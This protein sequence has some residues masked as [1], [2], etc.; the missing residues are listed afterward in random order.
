MVFGKKKNSN[1]YYSALKF[2]THTRQKL[3]IKRITRPRRHALIQHLPLW[4][5]AVPGKRFLLLSFQPSFHQEEH[6]DAQKEAWLF[7]IYQNPNN[8]LYQGIFSMA[9]ITQITRHKL[10]K[11][12][13]VH[14][15][16]SSVCYKRGQEVTQRCSMGLRI[17]A[18]CRITWVFPHQPW[19]NTKLILCPKAKC[20][21]S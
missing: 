11:Q 13:F 16:I 12:R 10:H 14:M 8:V 15:I 17:R 9:D 18:L 4:E 7:F 3:S 20:N 2:S 1:R 6:H 21:D 19:H 5:T